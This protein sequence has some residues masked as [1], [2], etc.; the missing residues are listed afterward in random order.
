MCTVR[1]CRG[2]KIYSK[3]W[4]RTSKQITNPIKIQTE[5][6]KDKNK[7]HNREIHVL[8]TFDCDTQWQYLQ[9]WKEHLSPS[10]SI[11]PLTFWLF[12]LRCRLVEAYSQNPGSSEFSLT[13]AN[14]LD[15]S[16]PGIRLLVSRQVASSLDASR[17]GCRLVANMLG[18]R[19]KEQDGRFYAKLRMEGW[20]FWSSERQA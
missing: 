9:Q 4:C 19:L 3:K 17:Q 20:R 18:I 13:D 1:F 2:W 7:K 12:R 14:W 15:I 11:L 8:C 5:N 16:R 6:Q 10:I